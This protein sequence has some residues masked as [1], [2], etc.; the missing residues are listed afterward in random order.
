[1]TSELIEFHSFNTTLVVEKTKINDPDGYFVNL[2]NNLQ[3]HQPI[4]AKFHNFS[5]ISQF[6]QTRNTWNIWNS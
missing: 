5:Q 3:D 2:Q 1:M 6:Q 4:S